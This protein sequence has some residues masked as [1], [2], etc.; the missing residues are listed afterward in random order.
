LFQRQA[1]ASFWDECAP[2]AVFTKRKVGCHPSFEAGLA[3]LPFHSRVCKSVPRC[4]HATV[5]KDLRILV[6]ED[7]PAEVTNLERALRLGRLDCHL[8]AVDTQQSFV[9]EL[10]REPPD[11]IL[12]ERNLRSFDGLSALAIARQWRPEIPFIFVA[13]PTDEEM[14]I[15]GFQ[16][17]AADY[18]LKSR[19]P[20]LA[21]AIERALKKAGE[22]AAQKEQHRD[23]RDTEERHRTLVEF[24]PDAQLVHDGERI[25]FANAAALR[26]LGAQGTEQLIGKPTQLI[27]PPDSWEAFQARLD[28]L[29]PERVGLPRAGGQA[30]AHSPAE[31]TAAAAFIETKF[32]RLDGTTVEVQATAA[33]L[34]F[35]HQPAVQIVARDATYPSQRVKELHRSQARLA[36]I[37][38]TALDAIIALDR[39]GRIQE[40]NPA[41]Q[42]MFG[43]SRGEVLG[44]AMDELIVP[45]SLRRMYEKGL[46]H[47]MMT[48]VGSLLNRPVELSLRRADGAEFRAEAAVT[49]VRP[50][51]PSG[52]T[53][54]IRD[55]TERK[56]AEAALR[57]SE[58]RLRQMIEDVKD[59]AIYLLDA[60]G[61]LATWNNGAEQIQGYSAAEI[62][63]KHY[64]C[65]FTPEDIRRGVPDQAL[66]RARE[67]GQSASE[68]W[69]VRKDGS[70]LWV[71]STTTALRDESGRI[72]G[73]SK[74]AHNMTA[75]KEAKDEIRRLNEQLEQRVRERTAQLEAANQELEAFSYSVSHDLRAPLRHIA[76]YVEIL[77]NEA[78]R[79]DDAN[80][81]HLRIISD[82]AQH[83]GRLIDALLAFSRMGR[84]EMRQQR[85]SLSRIIQEARNQL[86]QETEGRVIEWRIHPLPNVRADPF[87]LR[88]VFINLLS[89][90]IKFTRNRPR[91]RI[92]IGAEDQKQA[93]VCYVRDNGV[94]FDMQYAGKLF[95]VFERLHA[96]GE[97]E[98]T[99]IGLA[100]VRRI[101]HR[102]GGQTW[103]EG[104]LDGGASFYFSLPKQTKAST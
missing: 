99:G 49:L 76:S 13:D 46:T 86:H 79:L 43:Y 103:A 4:G 50:E 89:N 69:R 23:L 26:L 32:A 94:G 44:R 40:W 38:E 53:V 22:R 27:V 56:Q 35:Q 95:G 82:S 90:A 74:V 36:A 39:Q 5:K 3:T 51:D 78:S 93:T 48:G 59:Y 28:P 2:F 92:E 75:A 68:G 25:V 98:G 7:R 31:G 16:S 64:S 97:F 101:I 67:E 34:I 19:L 63:G 81:H 70:R 1:E 88:Q 83:M 58:E 17:G 24:C 6:V 41:A 61:R 73:F 71:H 15:E 85:V 20:K 104:V 42:R 14:A 47:Y 54:L 77:N 84:A 102:H 18:I 30:K 87:M 33:P 29:L 21:P 45:A 65:F 52:C 55:I 72:Y 60:D 62:I 10:E 91:A 37:L 80:K 8:K 66:Q 100:N 9:Q 57:R 11:V 96:A 12:S